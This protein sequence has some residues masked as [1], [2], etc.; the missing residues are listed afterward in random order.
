M[1]A[2]S[3]HMVT[4]LGGRKSRKVANNTYLKRLENDDVV[5]RLHETDILTAKPN[6]SVVVNTGS[7][8][9]VTTKARLN[10]WIKDGLGIYQ[11]RGV[12][13]WTKRDPNNW[14]HAVFSDG[15]VI[16]PRGA[17]KASADD[18]E[19]KRV[20]KL[21]SKINAFAKLCASQVPMDPPGPGDCLYCQMERE[22]KNL[23]TDHLMSHMEEGYVVPSLVYRA[24]R[25]INSTDFLMALTFS[26]GDHS[27]SRSVAP[28]HVQR[29]VRRYLK[30][31]FAIGG[32]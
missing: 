27:M 10:D 30:R 7:W 13:Y 4:T 23:D 11:N 15:D 14:G 16:G 1:S 20:K 12:W 17:L 24:L 26:K 19:V 2:T 5:L 6:G 3:K 31:R 28:M 29:A 21:T 25:E 9:T 8:R 18:E 32:N 22:G